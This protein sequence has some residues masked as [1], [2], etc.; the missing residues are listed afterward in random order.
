VPETVLQTTDYR[1]SLSRRK[2]DLPFV[3][4]VREAAQ[5]RARRFDP[6]IRP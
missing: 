3:A 4:P 5:D 1:P 6:S 2:A